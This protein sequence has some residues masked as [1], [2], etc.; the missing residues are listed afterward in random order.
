M[1]GVFA[2]PIV[3]ATLWFMADTRK[4]E[5]R[6]VIVLGVLA[7]GLAFALGLLLE[8]TLARPRPFVALGFDPLFSHAPD[9]SFPSDHTL[10]GVAFVG[11]I[12]LARRR[13]AVILIAWAVIVGLARVAAGV[14]F[15]SDIIG[16]F[17]LAQVLD[18]LVARF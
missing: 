18:I 7:A 9:S 1:F 3:Q 17:A 4:H 11:P 14:H 16:S 15:P 12:W 13:L 10:V 5:I 6:T 2:L 8:R